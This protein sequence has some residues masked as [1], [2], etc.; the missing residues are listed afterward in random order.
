MLFCREK[1]EIFLKNLKI[2]EDNENMISGR[3]NKSLIGKNYEVLVIDVNSLFLFSSVK[4][5]YKFIDSIRYY[6]ENNNML[7]I[8]VIDNGLNRKIMR[9]YPQYKANRITSNYSASIQKNAFHGSKS[10]KTKIASIHKIDKMINNNLTFYLSGE[11]DFKIGYIL[12]FIN[13]KTD[14][15]PSDILTASF[16]KDLI[17]SSLLS[18]VLLKR[19]KCKKRLWCKFDRDNQNIDL[20]KDVLKLEKFN[21]RDI[22]DFY[23]FLMVNGDDKDNIPQL[24]TKGV[25]IKLLNQV[26]AKYKCLNIDNIFKEIRNFGDISKNDLEDNAFLVDI[27]NSDV[28]TNQEKINMDYVLTNF[29]TSNNIKVH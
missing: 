23:Y 21:M 11:S 3:I 10:F 27:Y 18:D 17:L 8:N 12:N 13:T 22:S 29:F 6:A 24:L 19:F 25:T 26:I 9:R 5:V 20:L 14:I 2:K 7:V 4:S 1:K 15:S 28:F 16:D